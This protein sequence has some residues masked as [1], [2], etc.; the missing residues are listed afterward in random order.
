MDWNTH[1]VRSI[2]Y[3]YL[4]AYIL[5]IK[6]QKCICSHRAASDGSKWPLLGQFAS[7][8][9]SIHRL[10]FRSFVRRRIRRPGFLLLRRFKVRWRWRGLHTLSDR[11][12]SNDNFLGHMSSLQILG[13]PR[14]QE[15]RSQQLLGGGW[16]YQ[17]DVAQELTS[18]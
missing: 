1:R 17:F 16:S 3:I 9:R 15:T 11:L 5:Q 6:V 8:F 18:T 13:R 12:G 4:H 10:R 14:D 2:L 7:G